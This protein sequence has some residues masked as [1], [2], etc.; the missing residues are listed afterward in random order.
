MTAKPL[1]DKGFAVVSYFIRIFHDKKIRITII[2]STDCIA[3]FSRPDET[4][5]V[6]DRADSI[7][8]AVEKGKK[9]E[10]TSCETSGVAVG[11]GGSR[12]PSVSV[13]KKRGWKTRNYPHPGPVL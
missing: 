8:V 11:F 6:Q 4:E 10:G 9:T 5:K 2:L 13:V 12:N 3:T 1:I 7:R